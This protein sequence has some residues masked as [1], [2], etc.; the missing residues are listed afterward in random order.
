MEGVD[1]I[2][3][4]VD[5][6]GRAIGFFPSEKGNTNAYKVPV[7]GE[8]SAGPAVRMLGRSTKNAFTA[9]VEWRSSPEGQYLIAIIP[10]DED[11]F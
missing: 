11:I 8:M 1:Y 3:I 10:D 5:A 2:E 7:S 4:K 9:Q 6:K